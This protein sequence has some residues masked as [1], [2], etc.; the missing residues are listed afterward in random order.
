MSGKTKGFESVSVP[1]YLIKEIEDL[2]NEWEH[3]KGLRARTK[4]GFIQ[5]AIKKHI[6]YIKLLNIK[7]K[8]KKDYLKIINH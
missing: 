5:E 1:T 3:I 4:S 8:S 7:E 2:L 6:D